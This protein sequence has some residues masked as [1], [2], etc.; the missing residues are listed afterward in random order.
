MT[1]S[2]SSGRMTSTLP[3]SS[4]AAARAKPSPAIEPPISRRGTATLAQNQTNAMS[5]SPVFCSDS[6]MIWMP[7]RSS[8]IGTLLIRSVVNRQICLF[9]CRSPA[10]EPIVSAGILPV[11][12]R[13]YNT[14]NI[15]HDFYGSFVQIPILFAHLIFHTPNP[16]LTDM[17][18]PQFGIGNC[19]FYS[20]AFPPGSRNPVF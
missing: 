4:M 17:K 19:T 7:S 5:Q 15:F 18:K 2:A 10:F 11:K 12:S 3:H 20:A 8:F 6:G 13:L 14:P 9:F 1:P 16:A